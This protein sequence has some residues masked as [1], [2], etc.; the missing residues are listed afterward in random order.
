MWRAANGEFDVVRPRPALRSKAS[1]SPPRAKPAKPSTETPLALTPKGEAVRERILTV[2]LEAF[3]H[4]GFKSATTREISDAAGVNLPALRYY[5]GGKEELYVACAEAVVA[6]Y[7]AQTDAAADQARTMLASRPSPDAA[8]AQLKAIMHALATLLTG[9]K[10]APIWGR[11]IARQMNDTSKGL[12]ILQKQLW[13]PGIDLVARLI[14]IIGDYDATHSRIRAIWLISNATTFQA[15]RPLL[16][17]L[18]GWRQIGPDELKTLF[19]LIDRQIDE[20]GTDAEHL[21]K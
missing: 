4:K 20:I 8:R 14:S 19:S 11:F 2:A 13:A 17:Q 21:T 10:E 1:K 5:F 18:T 6:R 12:E 9:S 7:R 3:A 15:G 16:L